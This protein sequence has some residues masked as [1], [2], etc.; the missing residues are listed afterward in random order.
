[1]ANAD[2]SRARPFRVYT[3]TGL[4]TDPQDLRSKDGK[5]YRKVRLETTLNGRDATVTALAFEEALG[6]VDLSEGLVS[7]RCQVRRNLLVIVGEAPAARA[8]ATA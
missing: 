3:L 1:M 6:S 5:P 8:Q 2:T 7:L 4:L